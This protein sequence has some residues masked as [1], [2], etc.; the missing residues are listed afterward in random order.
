MGKLMQLAGK[1]D[2][3]KIMKLADQVDL[4]E[5]MQVVSTMEPAT[6]KKMLAGL[7]A[8]A[9]AGDAATNGAANG[10]AHPDPN[11]DFYDYA[12]TLT[13]PQ[14]AMQQRV[15]AFMEA[16]VRPVIN[17]YWQRD[18]TP[19]DLL[20]PAF[21][22]MNLIREIFNDD[23]TRKPGAAVTEG[24]LTVELAR[25]D[26]STATFFGVHSG[27]ALWSVIMGG[28]E[29]QKADWLPKMFDLEV[30]GAFGLTE[31]KVGSGAAG[32]L[33]TT[34]RREGDTWVLNGE[35]KWIGNATFADFIVVMARD[36]DSQEVKGFLVRKGT[37][38]LSVE[39]ILGKIALRAVENGH[40]TLKDCRVAESDR[41]QA[42]QGW[43]TVADVLRATRAGVA[44]QGVGCA[45][46]AYE[47]SLAYSGSRKQ[48]GRPIAG[49]QLIQEK[50]V[51]MLGSVTAC[52]AMCLRL[53][54]MQD[55]GTM[56]DEHASLAK[57]FTAARCREVVALA[58][59][60]HGGNGILL[61][62]EVARYFCDTEAIYS[63]E[64]TNEI[65]TLVV[66][67]AITGISAFV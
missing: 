11:G 6:L 52:Y 43:R 55:A 31:P 7:K 56:R 38:G 3:D 20:L 46:G 41:L 64:G 45:L 62:H 39:K 34:C 42:M 5:L 44:W 51:G 30:I 54:A 33:C 65:N 21:R 24:I 23:G 32:G 22:E 53:S 29:A 26:V 15:R 66:G 8:A 61:E 37:P 60:L 12:S 58:R 18:E 49:F 48:F 47:R 28:S 27:L 50:L 9:P 14:R 2:L 40:V 63:Y 4:G 25:V 10:Q 57:V 35:K 1:M 19:R 67:R 16:E 59:D 17:D 36:E 13:E